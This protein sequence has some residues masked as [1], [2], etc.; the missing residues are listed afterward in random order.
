MPPRTSRRSQ[1]RV[2]VTV[3]DIPNILQET[4][5]L[6]AIPTNTSLKILWEKLCQTYRLSLRHNL[7]SH[8]FPYWILDNVCERAIPLM[9]DAVYEKHAA[10]F[11]SWPRLL[12]ERFGEELPRWRVILFLGPLPQNRVRALQAV[13]LGR[14]SIT[15]DSVFRRLCDVR[16]KTRA[17]ANGPS[18]FKAKEIKACCGSMS[19]D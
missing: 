8:L 7:T 2:P 1:R 12:S 10:Q 11:T 15:L 3:D 16:A 9:I 18:D 19:R 5:T 6:V 4:F 14:T 13:T 17:P